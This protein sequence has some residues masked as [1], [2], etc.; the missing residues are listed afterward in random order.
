[1]TLTELDSL[2]TQEAWKAFTAFSDELRSF[3]EI[4]LREMVRFRAEYG[5]TLDQGVL[6]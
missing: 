5:P 1:V 2:I 6:G 4:Q 3:H